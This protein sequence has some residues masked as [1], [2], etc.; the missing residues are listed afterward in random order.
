MGQ[1]VY[2]ICGTGYIVFVSKSV[3]AY[4]VRRFWVTV[5]A[6]LVNERVVEWVVRQ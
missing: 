5:T 2:A 6:L 1:M 4:G 3:K